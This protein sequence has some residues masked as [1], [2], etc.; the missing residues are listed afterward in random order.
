MS[1]LRAIYH[2]DYPL[3]LVKSAVLV[4]LASMALIAARGVIL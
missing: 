4:A 3:V 2:F 1:A